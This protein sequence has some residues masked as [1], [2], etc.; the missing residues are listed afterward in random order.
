MQAL[1]QPLPL[2]ASPPLGNRLPSPDAQAKG[3]A[4]QE[5]RDLF[6]GQD[7]RTPRSDRADRLQ[8]RPAVQ[9]PDPSAVDPPA[10]GDVPRHSPGL[11]A[12]R[13]RL[14]G[15]RPL[16]P[17]RGASNGGGHRF[18]AGKGRAVPYL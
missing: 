8:D 18:I 15:V 13:L 12:L 7:S 1:L 5:G 17:T 4:I 16:V 6:A 2:Y 10:D 11:A 3:G 9:L 14:R